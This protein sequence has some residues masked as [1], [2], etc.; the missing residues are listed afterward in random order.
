MRRGV[1]CYAVC[2][3]FDLFSGFDS[4]LFLVWPWVGGAVAVLYFHVLGGVRIVS[5]YISNG[6]N[7]G[8]MGGV[9][10]LPSLFSLVLLMNVLGMVPYCFGLSCH[11]STNLGLALAVW[12]AVIVARLRFSL[13]G[14]LSHF[15]P[16]GGPAALS[17]FLCIIELVRC[18][19]RPVTLSVRLAA[20][21]ST[22]HIFIGLMSGAAGLLPVG[23]GYFIFEMAVATIQTYIFCLLPILYI[24]DHPCHIIT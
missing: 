17:P 3:L 1:S 14:T 23:A 8:K 16:T 5:S 7:L 12:G 4:G 19:I 22:G 13:V 6:T 11:L 24:E 21:L 15:S 18:L 2:L 9:S 10:V 20:N